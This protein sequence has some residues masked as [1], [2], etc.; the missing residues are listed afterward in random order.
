MK[1]FQTW[2]QKNNFQTRLGNIFFNFVIFFKNSSIVEQSKRLLQRY[3]TLKILNLFQHSSS[4]AEKLFLL[5]NIKVSFFLTGCS[6]S[7]E[8]LSVPSRYTA[9]SSPKHTISAF[10]NLCL[11]CVMWKRRKLTNRGQGCHLFLKKKFF[12]GKDQ[13]SKRS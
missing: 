10:I 7:S 1:D 12:L 6:Q 13:S 9:G 5:K 4:S 2:A 3:S 8:D 11:N